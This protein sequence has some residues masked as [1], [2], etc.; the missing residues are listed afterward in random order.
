M[1][2]ATGDRGIFALGERLNDA[3]G[4]GTGRDGFAAFQRAGSGATA[5]QRCREDGKWQMANGRRE[6]SRLFHGFV[7]FLHFTLYGVTKR[8]TEVT[9]RVTDGLS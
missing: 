9:K 8:V 1:R 3:A 6:G 4:W 2:L 7:C 5:K